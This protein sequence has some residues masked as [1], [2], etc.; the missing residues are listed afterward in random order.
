MDVSLSEI[1][2]EEKKTN[3]LNELILQVRLQVMLRN[4]YFM[5]YKKICFAYL[6]FS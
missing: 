5:H 3:I 2:G 6:F 1:Y 4:A